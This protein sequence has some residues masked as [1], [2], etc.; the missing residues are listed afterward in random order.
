VANVPEVPEHQFKAVI[1]ALLNTPPMP[2]SEI[3][4]K[5]ERKH[6]AAVK[7]RQRAR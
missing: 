5:R 6:K 3:P 4:R 2:L 7:K 1:R